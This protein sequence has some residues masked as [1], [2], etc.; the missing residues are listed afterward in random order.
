M[1]L[2][3]PNAFDESEGLITPSESESDRDVFV[4]RPGHQTKRRMDS[5]TP[6]N[7]PLAS[8]FLSHRS[9]SF[10]SRSPRAPQ[11]LPTKIG[12]TL[13]EVRKIDCPA[14]RT[15]F[16]DVLDQFRMQKYKADAAEE[17]AFV[18]AAMRAIGGLAGA[19]THHL[20][21][22]D[23]Q[24]EEEV[25]RRPPSQ[26]T[27]DRSRSSEVARRR[28]LRRQRPVV[29][30]LAGI[31][32]VDQQRPATFRVDRR[33]VWQ[34]IRPAESAVPAQR[35]AEVR[36]ER[37]G[38]AAPVNV[39]D[40]FELAD[41]AWINPSGEDH[42]VDR[43]GEHLLI[44]R[45]T[46][47]HESFTKAFGLVIPTDMEI[48]LFVVSDQYRAG[49]IWSSFAISTGR[50]LVQ[51]LRSMTTLRHVLSLTVFSFVFC[52]TGGPTKLLIVW[53]SNHDFSPLLAS[54]YPLTYIYTSP[55][56]KEDSK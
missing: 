32:T 56:Q 45:G 8:P 13:R 24:G 33:G 41:E 42:R 14:F 35:L 44:H 37:A 55:T 30:D 54:H 40:P 1:A 6:F 3:R 25:R 5:R 52:L 15:A 43:Q 9:C 23:E 36:P 17:F 4:L 19:W 38:Q 53:F 47:V 50:Q 22:V 2:R 34:L 18:R 20:D 10:R 31:P 7:S 51:H 26:P 21:I 12:Y 29:E 39:G 49:S 27:P 28:E 11:A 16:E 46:T 48:I